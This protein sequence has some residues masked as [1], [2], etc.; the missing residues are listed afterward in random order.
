MLILQSLGSRI[1]D[2]LLTILLVLLSMGSCTSS[3]EDN[4]SDQVQSSATFRLTGTT[5]ASVAGYASEPR[6]DLR[7]PQGTTYT[8][9]ILEGGAWCHTSPSS[10]ATSTTGR[11]V[12]TMQSAKIYLQDNYT[13]TP[14][15][16][17]IEVEYSTG[18]SVRLSL[19][20]GTY[21][22]PALFAKAWPELPDYQDNEKTITVT[23]YAPLSSSKTVRNFT[24]CFDK[25]K[26]YADWVAYPIHKSY[27]NG[28]YKRTD[29]WAY[30]PKIPTEYQP[31]LMT[32][33]YRGSWVRGHQVMSNH[34]YV[35]YSDE[36]N[37]QTFYSSNI[38]PQ[39]YD[40]NG[41]MWLNMEEICTKKGGTSGTDTLYCVTGTYG[42]R[43]TTTDKAGK[44]V[45]VPQYCFK[46]LLKARS[47][48]NATPVSQITDP[49][50]LMAIGYMA[51]NDASSNSGR[52]SDYTMSVAEVEA[53][54]GYRFF[55]M[56]DESVAEEVKAQHK[57]SDWNIN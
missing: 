52:L 24:V 3:Q 19:T 8:L 22:K 50:A 17:Q 51:L 36:L 25:E 14:R 42:V 16:A 30:D 21:D 43:G 40:F 23:H 10:E 35:G 2:H 31:N 47:T 4:A 49:N 33:S 32:G 37:A 28:S 20:Q 46:V 39:D 11:M 7:A 53:R 13:D 12:S 48:K 29:D 45:S 34:R 1:V 18:V 6:I 15:T 26:G 41:G 27:M 56:L 57:P 55:P 5:T 9:S 38:M 54:T 44:Q